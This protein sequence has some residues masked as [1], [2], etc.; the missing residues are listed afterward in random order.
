MALGC[1]RHRDPCSF[2]PA[3]RLYLM[4]S[5][6]PCA[7]DSPITADTQ[8]LGCAQVMNS[9]GWE[10]GKE[11]KSMMEGSSSAG[12]RRDRVRS[13][14][15]QCAETP[16]GRSALHAATSARGR[17]RGDGVRRRPGSWCDLHTGS[18]GNTKSTTIRPTNASDEI[19]SHLLP[20]SRCIAPSAD[21]Q[22]AGL[23]FLRQLLIFSC[24]FL[25]M[26]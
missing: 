5:L 8:F 2:S 10:P 21:L 1:G 4:Q 12:S 11:A 7:S 23:V 9:D 18:P 20:P 15:G 16:L 22:L 17:C 6:R 25:A 14:V 13:L 3:L 26:R 19:S 24:L